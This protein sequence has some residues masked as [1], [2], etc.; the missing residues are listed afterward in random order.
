MAKYNDYLYT[1]IH[2]G[3][4]KGFYIKDIPTNYLKWVVMNHVDRGVCE[5]IAIE[6]QRRDKSLR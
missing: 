4:Y 6:L 2:F 5:M 1:Q 3:K